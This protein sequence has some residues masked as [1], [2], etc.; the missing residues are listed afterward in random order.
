MAILERRNIR[1]NTLDLPQHDK[2]AIGVT[3]PFD[4]PAVFNSSYQTKDQVKSNLINLLLT[5]PGERL[6]Q[7]DF[8]IGIR[9]YLFEQ[10]IDKTTIKNKITDG[11]QSHLPEIEIV[12]LFIKRENME[13]TPEIHTVR[14]SIYYRLL[15]DNSMD[16]IEINYQ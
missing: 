5:D 12:D 6:M 2:V 4:G 9:R 1:I 13:T 11:V 10:T 14:M 7:P 8:G 16:A 3:L 15:A